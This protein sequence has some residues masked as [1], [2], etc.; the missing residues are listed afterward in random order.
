MAPALVITAPPSAGPATNAA[1]ASTSARQASPATTVTDASPLAAGLPVRGID[2]MV[3]RFA[4]V[5]RGV[6]QPGARRDR[7]LAQRASRCS[8]WRA[9]RRPRPTQPWGSGDTTAATLE[10]DE[11]R[12]RRRRAP[13]A[14]RRS[15][16]PCHGPDAAR[17]IIVA[18]E[19]DRGASRSRCGGHAG[20]GPAPSVATASKSRSYPAATTAGRTVGSSARRCPS[21]RAPRLDQCEQLGRDDDRRAG[22]GVQRTELARRP[23]PAP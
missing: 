1:L 17:T 10:I 9:G 7:T 5:L 13:G 3:E 16:S 4:V 6:P 8:R 23:E 18:V 19:L 11:R 14:T 20:P 12:Q 15:A 2:Q 21:T 22:G